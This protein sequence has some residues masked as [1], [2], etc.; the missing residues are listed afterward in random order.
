MTRTNSKKSVALSAI[1]AIVVLMALG[2]TDVFGDHEADILVNEFGD[3]LEGVEAEILKI[4]ADSEPS[5]NTTN[6]MP[7]GSILSQIAHAEAFDEVI[8]KQ[9]L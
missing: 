5:V 7:T 8:R 1:M 2:V 6:T 4:P 9:I 3:L